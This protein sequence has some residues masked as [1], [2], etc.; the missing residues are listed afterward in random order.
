MVK[1]SENEKEAKLVEML[2]SQF[3]VDCEIKRK[4]RV[5][6]KIDRANLIDLCAL[7]KR[8]GFEHLSAI[9]VTPM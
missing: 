8:H 5:S 1:S 4:R 2:K 6:V 3:K 7:V 9:A